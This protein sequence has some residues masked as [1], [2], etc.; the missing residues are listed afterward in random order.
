MSEHKI[1]RA[2]KAVPPTPPAAPEP[3]KTG[4]KHERDAKG[5]FQAGTSPNPKG[6]PAGSRNKATIL[7]M[8]QL[9]EEAPALLKRMIKKAKA[10]DTN[11]MKF[12]LE[13][14]IPP[15]KSSPVDVLLPDDPQRASALLVGLAASG[16]LS[17][18]DAVDLAELVR[19]HSDL[20]DLKS[21]AARIEALEARGV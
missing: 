20:T 12:L 16:Q 19:L 6:R 4:G 13:R 9:Q 8:G 3:A 18:K 7:L 2:G 14:L 11:A 17:P 1:R 10:G 5:R 15:C 21:L